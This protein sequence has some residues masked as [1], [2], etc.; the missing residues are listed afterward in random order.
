ME[1]LE[2]SLEDGTDKLA[3]MNARV[4]HLL[5]EALALAPDE[6]SALVVALMDS[7]DGED[8]ATV[9]KAWADEIRRRK[10]ELRSGAASAVPW[11]EAR[12]RLTAL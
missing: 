12:A 9:T 8:E 1:W 11:A 6:R 3:G 7:L 4:D 10:D 5:D 2:A